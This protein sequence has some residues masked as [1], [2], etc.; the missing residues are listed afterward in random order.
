MDV[1]SLNLV[2]AQ[3]SVHVSYKVAPKHRKITC[4]LLEK[5]RVLILGHADNNYIYWASVSDCADKE[6]NEKI[7][8]YISKVPYLTLSS[9]HKIE[10]A[11]ERK[12]HYTCTFFPSERGWSTSFDHFYGKEKNGYFFALDMANLPNF[13]QTK[14]EARLAGNT[15]LLVLNAYKNFFFELN[16]DAI[17][18]Y[19]KAKPIIELLGKESYL[20][21]AKEE[22][23]KEVY[24]QLMEKSSE[25]YN[26]Y[27][28]LVR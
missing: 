21:N 9:V 22:E 11:R 10:E 25:L 19:Y 13:V 17:S 16:E 15:Y 26:A 2:K 7:F 27:M 8:E 1:L 12:N 4:T 14:C 23:V 18:N 6:V 20:Y 24:R 5:N 28:S 3:N